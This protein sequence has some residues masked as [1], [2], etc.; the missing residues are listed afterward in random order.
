MRTFSSFNQIA[1]DGS[2]YIPIKLGKIEFDGL[3]LFVCDR[4]FGDPGS[5]N[6]WQGNIYEP[7][8]IS[9]GQVSGGSLNPITFDFENTECSIILNNS[10]PIGGFPK[11]TSILTSYH[12]SYTKITI[13]EIFEGASASED[14]IDRFIGYFEDVTEMN[15]ISVTVNCVGIELGIKNKFVKT[16]IDKDNYVGADPD[17]FGKMLPI[18]Y[19]DCKRVP[20]RAVDAGSITT[21]ESE[22]DESSSVIF[23]TDAYQFPSSGGTIQ[24]DLEQITYTAVSGNTLVGCSRGAN[25]TTAVVH[26][27]G[28]IVAEIQSSYIYIIDHPVSSIDAVYVINRNNDENI[29]QTANFVVY[30]GKPGDQHGSYPG[31][32]VIEFTLLPSITQQVN[33]EVDDTIDVDDAIEIYEPG[34][35]HT[36]D[37]GSTETT[38]W[39]YDDAYFTIGDDGV[40]G[41]DSLQYFVDGNIVSSGYLFG[42]GTTVKLQKTFYEEPPNQTISIRICMHVNFL[43]SNTTVRAYYGAGAPGTGWVSVPGTTKI[44]WWNVLDWETLNSTLVTIERGGSNPS[45]YAGVGLVWLEVRYVTSAGSTAYVTKVDTVYKTGTVEL[46]GNSVADTVIGGAVSADV[47]GW[48]ADDSGN[49]GTEGELVNRPDYILKHFFVEYC[50]LSISENIGSSYSSVGTTYSDENIT[51]NIVIESVPDVLEL[52]KFC[53][54][55]SRS[56]GWWDNSQHNLKYI[57]YTESSVKTIEAN[58]INLKSIRV[59]YTPRVDILNSLSALYHKEWV[60]AFD[61]PEE[62]Y[63]DIVKASSSTS[64]GMFGV[65]EGE[66]YEL[67]FVGNQSQ[68]E[69]VLSWLLDERS[70]PRL[71][72]EFSGSLNLSDLQIGDSVDFSFD[73]DSQLDKAFLGLVTSEV[74]IFRIIEWKSMEKGEFWIRGISVVPSTSDS[75]SFASTEDGYTQGSNFYDDTLA[76]PIGD[77]TGSPVY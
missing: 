2:N 49:Y 71:I 17:E 60:G 11:F 77:Y 43:D 24:I 70:F 13:S 21:L 38:L 10:K 29:L 40:F 46:T 73:A 22:L 59:S 30:T 23:L 12:L 3:T 47:K 9:W 39:K 66:Q 18:V 48:V 8:I 65:L 56:L 5:E 31:K 52:V 26:N 64:Q 6:T 44:G 4:M 36:T 75:G 76:I 32:A 50:G 1:L 74:S 58:R 61:E 45:G 62:F 19:G 41:G 68:A 20:F 25:D 27:V 15:Q 72:I 63:R 53:L 67:D 69:R 42:Q 34:H 35:A 28:A 57:P 55:Q 37:P 54:V 14:E 51:L 16:I 33:L 7:V